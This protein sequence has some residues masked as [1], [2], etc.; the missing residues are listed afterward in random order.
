[1]I[2]VIQLFKLERE[3][4]APDKVARLLQLSSRHKAEDLIQ[5]QL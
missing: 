4:V 3:L 1:M 5:Q 2:A